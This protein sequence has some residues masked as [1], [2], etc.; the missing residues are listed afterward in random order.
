MPGMLSS[1]GIEELRRVSDDGFDPLFISLMTFH[2]QG[3][4]A[5]ADE[6]LHG[7][8]DIRLR[9]MA[10]AIRHAQRGEI[11]LMRDTEGVAAVKAAAMSLILP[12]GR[13]DADQPLRNFPGRPGESHRH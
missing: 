8:S 13:A 6:T 5:M 4:I 1:D 9:L 7:R 11:E 2:H 12:A 10:H 3:A